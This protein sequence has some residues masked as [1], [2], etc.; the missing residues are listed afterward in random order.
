VTTS[1]KTAGELVLPPSA[2]ELGLFQALV[3][4]VFET[5]LQ[6]KLNDHG[7][8]ARHAGEGGV[9]GTRGTEASPRR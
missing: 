8:Y 5:R 7:G 6:A 9:L 1:K 3:G 4:R 2:Q